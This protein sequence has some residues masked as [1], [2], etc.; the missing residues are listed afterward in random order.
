MFKHLSFQ[1]WSVVV[2]VGLCVFTGN[3]DAANTSTA[4]ELRSAYLGPSVWSENLSPLEINDQLKDHFAEVLV[5]LEAKN[6]SS[7][8]TALIRAEASSVK[9]WSKSDRRTALIY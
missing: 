1:F 9:R 4:N 7:L 5:R 6:A 2:C 3:A 8:L